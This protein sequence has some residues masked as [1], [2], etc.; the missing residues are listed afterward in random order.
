MWLSMK[1]NRVKELL[2]KR[3]IGHTAK[4]TKIGETVY[5]C[6][7]FKRMAKIT[8]VSTLIS[9]EFPFGERDKQVFDNVKFFEYYLDGGKI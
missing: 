7:L 2:D 3:K 8:E 4:D 6:L 5:Q 9:V 1:N